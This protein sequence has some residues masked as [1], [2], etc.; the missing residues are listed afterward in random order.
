MHRIVV[1]LG[2]GDAGKGSIVDWLCR[3]GDVA[4]VVRFNGGAQAA[5]NVVTDDGRH[6]TFSQF[7][8][9]TFVPG[10]RTHLSRFMVIEPLALAAEARHLG[11]VGVPDALDRL[12]VSGDALITTPYHRTANHVREVARGDGRHGSCGV[13]V[14]ETVRLALDDP[15]TA[16]RVTDLADPRILR[17][18]L[19]AVRD[20]LV[21][22][23]GPDVL[24][25][26]APLD[27]I[28]E[29]F[30][31]FAAAV[32]VIDDRDVPD[33]ARGSL[34]FEGAQGVLLDEWRG[35]HPYTTWSTT[36]FDNAVTLAGEMGLADVH[37]LG[38][39][40]AYQTRHGAG[41]F[42]TED[43]RLYDSL[44]E[45]HNRTGA[46]QGPFRVGHLDLVALRYAIEV[47]GGAD[48]LAVT[49]L[50]RAE[51]SADLRAADAY[52]VARVGERPD[53]IE[54]LEPGPFTD[55]D[56]QS[57]LTRTLTE[58]T[59]VL[60]IPDAP[61]SDIIER[62]AGVPVEIESRGPTARAKHAVRDRSVTPA[63]EATRRRLVEAGG[64]TFRVRRSAPPVPTCQPV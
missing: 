58:V 12:S 61:W 24:D 29:T 32:A 43:P 13:G 22:E 15:A 11:D 19:R 52:R 1:D 2:Y 20:V 28:A 6:H 38:V 17:R 3:Q 5:H 33:Q 8:S 47:C 25:G 59:P 49:H 14:G 51:G 45:P 21:D 60:T 42:V 64:D 10:V 41:P 55:L 9:G 56:Y 16:L 35:F 40:R 30:G 50:D 23:L 27:A 48:S 62:V 4:T 34:L 31:R 26:V 39:T 63:S 18:R 53:V 57:T 44:P 37:R 54:R 7:G 36:T 46:W